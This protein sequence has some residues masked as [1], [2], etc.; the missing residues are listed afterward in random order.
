MTG[1]SSLKIVLLL[2]YYYYI[3]KNYLQTSYSKKLCVFKVLGAIKDIYFND[4]SFDS[5][6]HELHVSILVLNVPLCLLLPS[7]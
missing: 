5:S 6:D 2:Y 4:S 7:V 3:I 1:A